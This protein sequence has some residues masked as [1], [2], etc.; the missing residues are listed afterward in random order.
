MILIISYDKNVSIH[1]TLEKA[2]F[3]VNYFRL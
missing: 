2:A 3:A 1:K